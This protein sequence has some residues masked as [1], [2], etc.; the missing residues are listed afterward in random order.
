MVIKLELQ[1]ILPHISVGLTLLNIPFFCGLLIHGT[2]Y[3][4]RLEMHLLQFL[5]N[6]CYRKFVLSLIRFTI[7]AVLMT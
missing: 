3:I 1:E 6:T 5:R 7:F 4:Q 2:K